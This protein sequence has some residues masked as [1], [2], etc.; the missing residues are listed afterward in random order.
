MIKIIAIGKIKEKPMQQIIDEFAKR[1]KP[2]H[3]V[4]MVELP[5]S[6]K[7]ENEVSAILYDESTRILEKIEPK[8]FVVLLDLKGKDLS[9][10]EMSQKIMGVLDQSLNVSFVV[11]GSHGVDDRVRE[12]SNMRWRISNLTFPHQLVRVM[13]YEQLYRFFMIAKGHPYHK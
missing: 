4:V 12:R 1:L 13:L 8:E 5:N 3:Q 11:G 10:V 9:S 6:N 7:K 2:I